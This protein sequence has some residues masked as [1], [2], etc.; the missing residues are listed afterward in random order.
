L[1][2]KGVARRTE[3]SPQTGQKGRTVLLGKIEKR[4]KKKYSYK[5]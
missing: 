4:G 1:R 2:L 3:G 5:K